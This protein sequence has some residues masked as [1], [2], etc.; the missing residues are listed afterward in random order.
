MANRYCR[1]AHAMVLKSEAFSHPDARAGVSV[2]GKLLN[3]AAGLGLE[4]E[5]L[6]QP[7]TQAAYHIPVHALGEEIAALHT[8]VWKS[9]NRPREY[10]ASACTTR[11]LSKI[12]VPMVLEH[13]RKLANNADVGRKQLDY[14]PLV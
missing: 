10:G 4:A 3:V 12:T 6:A 13:L 14:G 11:Q 7:A 9:D 8:G 2:P 5:P 1:I